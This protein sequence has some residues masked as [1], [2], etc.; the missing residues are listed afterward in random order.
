MQRDEVQRA[1]VQR[2][3]DEVWRREA[4]RVVG[5][6]AR[7]TADLGL[8]EDLAQEA[9]AEALEQWPRSTPP[10]NPAA[11]LTTVAKRRAID[12]WRRQARLDDRYAA[13][14][15]DL[16]DERALDP[17]A[18][19]DPDRIDDD[20]LRVVF[21]ACHP[22]L[23]PEAR[24]ALTLRVVAGL[25]TAEIGR[26]LLVPVATV[27]QR[28]VRAKKTLRAARVPFEVPPRSE[29]ASRLDAVLSVV[30][31]LFNE[32][33][34]ATSGD[35]W[36]RPDVAD[37]ARRLG[38]I[39]QRVVPTEPEVHALV[40]LMEL[41]ASRFAA[42][43][44]PAGDVVLLPDQDRTL[45]D[46]AAITR[47]RAEL[48]RSDSFGQGRGRYALQAAIAEVH[49][50]AASADATD[51]DAIVVLYDALVALTPWPVVALNRAVAVSM[52]TGPATALRLVDALG[53]PLR[54][55]APLHA[56][57][58]ELLDKLGRTDGA[59]AAFAEA[60]ALTSNVPERALLLG[61]AAGHPEPSRKDAP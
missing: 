9:V 36:F 10:E 5:G 35:A 39:L 37:E 48:S 27:Q 11:W 56:V 34:V 15:R 38:R 32:G 19:F 16:D 31:L 43:V 1:D 59:R 28:I 25:T 45:W 51:W 60:A 17:A 2:L 22:V 47:G 23:S 6:L 30:Y 7:Y 12:L 40:S 3:L 42:R 46:R 54:G 21:V 29:F 4:A 33:Y 41:Q 8:A 58:G 49:A 53:G 18:S 26:A 61:R 50:T 13:L 57:R 44:T 55:Y 14:A 24:V 20:V 52:A